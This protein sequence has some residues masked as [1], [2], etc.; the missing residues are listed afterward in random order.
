MEARRKKTLMIYLAASLILLAVAG[1]IIYMSF[2]Q[3]SVSPSENPIGSENPANEAPATST[4]GTAST[5]ASSTVVIP[6]KTVQYA[7]DSEKTDML[8]IY[9]EPQAK[10]QV[11]S[12]DAKGRILDYKIIPSTSSPVKK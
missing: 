5:T 4:N 2:F 9:T 3:P 11:L 7:T 6:V 1:F 8:G 10:I 12:R